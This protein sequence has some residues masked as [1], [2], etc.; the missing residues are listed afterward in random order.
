MEIGATMATNRIS[1]KKLSGILT[2]ITLCTL[3][4]TSHAIAPGAN[5]YATLVRSISKEKLADV[6]YNIKN[7][8]P[9]VHQF[10]HKAIKEYD[11]HTIKEVTIAHGL[12]NVSIESWNK[13]RINITSHMQSNKADT[14]NRTRIQTSVTD[15][16]ATIKTEYCGKVS[17]GT[18]T[19]KIGKCSRINWRTVQ[20]T[21]A[22][23]TVDLF[24]K[25]PQKSYVTAIRQY[26][27]TQIITFNINGCWFVART[28]LFCF[29]NRRGQIG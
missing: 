7:K 1:I 24:I 9:A 5:K 20:S 3:T 6:W 4:C 12:G 25:L 17:K 28:K 14:F 10:Q 19:I 8:R 18:P 16:T 11:A 2:L 15:T 29:I 21:D 26:F 22:S 27:P 13:D 23:A